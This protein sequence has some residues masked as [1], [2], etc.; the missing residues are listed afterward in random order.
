[1][2]INSSTDLALIIK[3]VS[4]HVLSLRYLIHVWFCLE[5]SLYKWGVNVGSSVIKFINE[6]CLPYIVM[7]NSLNSTHLGNKDPESTTEAKRNYHSGCCPM[8]HAWMAALFI[9]VFIRRQ[10]CIM[11]TWKWGA[12]DYFVLCSPVTESNDSIHKKGLI[13]V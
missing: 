1:M 12:L 11:F 3:H 2:K 5:K 4:F 7:R 13:S 6:L 8:A 10:G 9:L